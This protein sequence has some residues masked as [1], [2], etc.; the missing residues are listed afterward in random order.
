MLEVM[1]ECWNN[2]D[3][4]SDYHWSVWLD[5]S[6]QQMGGRFERSEEAEAAARAYC[7]STYSRQPDRLR[8]L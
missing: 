3:G 7:Q 4:S 8:H 2:P 6:R 1:I 5:G